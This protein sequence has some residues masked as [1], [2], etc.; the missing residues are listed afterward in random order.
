M[1]KLCLALSIKKL[2]HMEQFL[3][4]RLF[5][6]ALVYASLYKLILT[7]ASGMQAFP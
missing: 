3:K 1:A 5:R 4:I 6:V 2:P 7:D